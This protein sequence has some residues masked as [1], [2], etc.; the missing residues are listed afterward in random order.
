MNPPYLATPESRLKLTAFYQDTLLNNVI[1]F[2][3]RHG[4]DRE[5]GGML[6]ALDRDGAVLDTDKSV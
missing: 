4:L 1:P 3:I 2:W 5:Y 6:T